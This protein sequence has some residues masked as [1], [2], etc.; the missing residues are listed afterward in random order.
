MKVNVIENDEKMIK[1][2]IEGEDHTFLNALRKQLWANPNVLDAT[3]IM[4]NSFVGNPIFKLKMRKGSPQDAL[5]TASKQLL[6]DTKELRKHFERN[7]KD[8]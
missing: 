5:K 4:K 8:R 3:Y 6:N 7:M 1:F 2:E